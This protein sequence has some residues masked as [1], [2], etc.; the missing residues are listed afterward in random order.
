MSWLTPMTVGTAMVRHGLGNSEEVKEV[1]IQILHI[2]FLHLIRY[3]FKDAI[4][5]NSNDSTFAKTLGLSTKSKDFS[6]F[7]KHL[8]DLVNTYLDFDYTYGNQPVGCLAMFRLNVSMGQYDK[9]H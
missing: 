9:F 4:N 5:Y 2:L 8:R 3:V 7:R 1:A 6:D